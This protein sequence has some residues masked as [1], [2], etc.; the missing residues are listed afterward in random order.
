MCA[1]PHQGPDVDG[2]TVLTGPGVRRLRS[3]DLVSARVDA[4]SGVDL[5]ARL[6]AR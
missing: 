6:E 1:A 5:R 3:G 4:S 2:V